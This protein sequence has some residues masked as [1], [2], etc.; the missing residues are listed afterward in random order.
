M[1]L[2]LKHPPAQCGFK[3]SQEPERV[4]SKIWHPSLI[5]STNQLFYFS[6]QQQCPTIGMALR[7]DS[8]TGAK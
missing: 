7:E 4:K 2:N 3:A 8:V 6:P 5:L 1:L